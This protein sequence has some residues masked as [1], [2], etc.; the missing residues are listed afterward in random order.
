MSR[1]MPN[2][3]AD[4]SLAN[5]A[6]DSANDG[7]TITDMLLPDQP[8][9]YINKAFEKMTGYKKSEVV[10]KNCRFLQGKLHQQIEL[11]IIR[12][13]IQNK[14]NCR[15]VL[16]NIKK[17]KTLFWN[18]LSLAPITDSNGKL[19]HYVGIQKDITNE[20]MQKEKII[21]LSE[22]DELTG[23]CNY[24]S[25]FRK[26]DDLI[27]R[28]AK[29]N[30]T[31]G[32]GIADIDCFKLINDRHGHLIGNNVLKIVGTALLQE[33]ITNQRYRSTFWWG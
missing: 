21:Y 27:M 17:N 25:F 19:T 22:Y 32:I 12:E 16:Q 3:L 20:V 4:I 23:L 15:V 30:L 9:I 33:F 28:A 11:A 13:A 10:G 1:K 6:L 24:R 29:E 5:Q 18:E 2:K 26:I 8:L 31:L 7:I 14:T